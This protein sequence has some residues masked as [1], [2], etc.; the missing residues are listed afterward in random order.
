MKEAKKNKKKKKKLN[1]HNV[2]WCCC[3]LDIGNRLHR[4]SV[5]RCCNWLWTADWLAD[6]M[7]DWST[8][9]LT[10]RPTDRPTNQP[11]NQPANQPSHKH[12]P[13]SSRSWQ[14]ASS[15]ASQAI[16]HTLRN[17]KFYCR[18]LKSPLLF[19]ILSQIN[20]ILKIQ[21]HTKT[22]S[23]PH[24]TCPTHLI[25]ISSH[26]VSVAN[27]AAPYYAISGLQRA[28]QLRPSWHATRAAD[29]GRSSSF[30]VRRRVA[31]LLP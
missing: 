14:V 5:M 12:T 10:D 18:A 7:S 4:E 1:I 15:S 2:W 24:V 28:E 19:P 3:Y 29:M 22:F 30:G 23:S 27:Q 17:P 13:Y 16:P 6:R 26:F 11:S 20:P 21:F 9:W 31:T 8:D 25:L